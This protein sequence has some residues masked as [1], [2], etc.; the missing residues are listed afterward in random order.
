MLAGIA[1]V[2]LGSYIAQRMRPTHPTIDAT[3]CGWSLLM[4]SPLVFFSLF[5]ARFLST[6]CYVL[7]FFAM[8]LL[9]M[10]WSIVADILL[11]RKR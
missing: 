11:V 2:P 6:A 9:N 5:G 3:L 8:L 4:S 1:G 10:T 7:V